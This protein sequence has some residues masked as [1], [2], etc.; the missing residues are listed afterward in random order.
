MQTSF[1][2]PPFGFALF[3]LRSVAS[4]DIRTSDIYW[5]A[6]PFV[7]I[8]VIMV[9]VVI[10]FPGIVTGNVSKAKGAISGT[11]ADEIRRQL[12]VPVAP[13][14]PPAESEPSRPQKDD[15]PAAAIERMLKEQK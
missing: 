14:A 1:L 3:Y 5:G 6:I 13:E 11:G 2:H 4:R 12:D 15:D 9:A 7:C 10:A 8:Q